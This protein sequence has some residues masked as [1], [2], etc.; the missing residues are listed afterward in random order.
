MKTATD[1]FSD[2]TNSVFEFSDD[3]RNTLPVIGDGIK[4]MVSDF[5]DV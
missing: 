4:N 3:S 1:L 2:D 5:G